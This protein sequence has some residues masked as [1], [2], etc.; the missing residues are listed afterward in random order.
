MQV[1]TDQFKRKV[2][3]CIQVVIGLL[4]VTGMVSFC[5]VEFAFPY[6]KSLNDDLSIW[7][8]ALIMATCIMLA[9]IIAFWAG[10]R[11]DHFKGLGQEK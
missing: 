5:L 6:V 9:F 8:N 2:E 4:I 1:F 3:Y 7:V 10:K 11:Y